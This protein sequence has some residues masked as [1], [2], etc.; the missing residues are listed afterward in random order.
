[1]R[2]VEKRGGGWIRQIC[3]CWRTFVSSQKVWECHHQSSFVQCVFFYRNIFAYALWAF[4]LTIQAWL[5]AIFS[6]QHVWSDDS[7]CQ[8]FLFIFTGGW[9][10][11]VSIN[12]VEEDLQQTVTNKPIGSLIWRS[13]MCIVGCSDIIFVGLSFFKPS[14]T[15]SGSSRASLY[16]SHLR[17][18]GPSLRYLKHVVSNYHFYANVRQE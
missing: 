4:G 1:M 17:R 16:P 18:H 3:L 9:G 6:K 8:T 2:R 14:R 13:C 11:G 7:H 10:G 15:W 5:S 12:S